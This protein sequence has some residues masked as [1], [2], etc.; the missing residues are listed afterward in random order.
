MESVGECHDNSFT[1]SGRRAKRGESNE[2]FRIPHDKL[3]DKIQ[4]W[5]LE[6]TELLRNVR[7][8]LHYMFKLLLELQTF[9]EQI[10]G[11]QDSMR[12]KEKEAQEMIHK[13]N[14]IASIV[15]FSV[16]VH[17][18]IMSEYEVSACKGILEN[19]FASGA[20]IKAAVECIK[21]TVDG[22]TR[23]LE[24]QFEGCGI[25]RL[26]QSNRRKFISLVEFQRKVDTL[27]LGFE[28]RMQGRHPVFLERSLLL[29]KSIQETKQKV[30]GNFNETKVRIE[31]RLIIN[32]IQ[33][34]EDFV[35]CM[36]VVEGN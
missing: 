24:K 30:L 15:K 28:Y 20:T 7:N 4:A 22:C 32:T 16:P 19:F 2:L 23:K 29:R 18:P 13:L 5:R 12:A 3:G 25:S 17:T 34:E 11:L 36:K 31:R 33:I 27:M 26:R 6:N 21:E 1:I 9:T 10:F 35:S 14:F 8:E